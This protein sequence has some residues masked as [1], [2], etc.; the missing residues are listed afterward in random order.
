LPA[1]A[2][3]VLLV[4]QRSASRIRG[5]GWAVL[6]V[7]TYFSVATTHDYIAC[8]RSRVDA[9][10]KLV[11]AGVPRNA[12]SAG[13]EYDLWTE[14]EDSGYVNDPRLVVPAGAFHS[15]VGRKYPVN[16]PHRMWDWAPTLTLQYVVVYSPQAGLT[17]SGVA[18]IHYRAWIPPFDRQVFVQ[19][20]GERKLSR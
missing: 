12:I 8:A 18:P 19:S 6:A 9:A 15:Q 4:Y 10:N 13:W 2:I 14:I 1:V 20:T 7:F 5:A 3:P 16:P 11:S 17:D